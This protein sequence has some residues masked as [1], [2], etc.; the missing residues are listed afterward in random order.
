MCIQESV[1]GKGHLTSLSG[2]RKC[3]HVQIQQKEKRLIVTSVH[4][5]IQIASGGQS[6][7]LG[8]DTKVFATVHDT[9]SS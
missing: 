7:Y 9:N 8:H 4:Y 1:R 6:R 2:R 5:I 3:C